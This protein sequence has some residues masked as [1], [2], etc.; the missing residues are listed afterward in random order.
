SLHPSA[1]PRHQVAT[2]GASADRTSASVDDQTVRN[3]VHTS[4][5]GRGLRV[6][7]SNVFGDEPLTFDAV[8]VGRQLEGAS[9]VPGSNRQLTFSGR[10]SVT[11]PPGAEV[12]SDPLPGRTP[13]TTD[14]AISVHLDGA[15]QSVT[16]HNLAEQTSYVSNAGDHAGE[17]SATAFTTTITDWY[18][19]DA[20]VVTEPKRL[21]TLVTFGDSITNGNHSTVGANRRWPDDLARRLLTLPTRR[22]FAVMNEGISGNRV[23]VDSSGESAQAR[24]DRDVL[25]QPDVETVILLEGIN[26]IRHDNAT[27]AGQLIAAYRQ[28]I[29]R[30]HADG[31]CI[32]GGTMTPFKG[33]GRYTPRREA[34]RQAVNHF[35]RTTG[36]FDS[37]VDFDR[38]TRDPQHPQRFLPAYDS[39]D[40]LHPNDAGYHAMAHAVQ[41]R[42]LDCHR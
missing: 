4:V 32:I 24:F 37:F 42:Q 29:S 17:E 30:A 31:V 1:A 22:R 11:I 20:V 35:V 23:L 15:T 5:A 25:A 12:L 7:L 41:L 40:S 14:L 9:L 13:P 38:A 39:G 2:W 8:Y 21:D 6:S 3:I 33:S 16:G 27:S 10:T 36:D 26:D 34:I 18:W 19:V 28:L